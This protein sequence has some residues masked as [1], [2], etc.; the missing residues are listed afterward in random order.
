MLLTGIIRELSD[1]PAVFARTL[2]YFF[3]QSSDTSLNSATA[4][5]RSLIWMLVIQQPHLISHLQADY[6]YSREALFT[7]KNALVALSRAFKNMLENARPVYF[8][9]DALD[10]C[11]D[12]LNDLINLISTSLTLPFKVRWL[13][14]SRPDVDVLTKLI[15]LNGKNPATVRTLAELD[16]CSQKDRVEKYIKHKLSDLK[17]SELGNTYTKEILATVTKNVYERAEDNALDISRVQ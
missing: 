17:G 13:V 10:E 2:S 16:V 14:S 9:V 7:D 1:Q 3:C 11:Y 4:T 6:K 5:L 15:N 12:G 8:I